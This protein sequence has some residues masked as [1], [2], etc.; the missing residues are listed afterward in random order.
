MKFKIN[1]KFQSINEQLHI[2]GAAFFAVGLVCILMGAVPPNDGTWLFVEIVKPI[3][4]YITF[5]I[6]TFI[7][8]LLMIIDITFTE[9]TDKGE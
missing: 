1:K 9:N 8:I 4:Y 2:G 7:G 6:L 3:N 5:G